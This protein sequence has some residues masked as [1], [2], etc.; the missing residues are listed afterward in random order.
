MG[1]DGKYEEVD[2]PEETGLKYPCP[3][4]DVDDEEEDDDGGPF[5]L[6]LLGLVFVVEDRTE[7]DDTVD[8]MAAAVAVVAVVVATA[9]VGG[10]RLVI[11]E[12]L[13]MLEMLL[14][15][16]LRAFD[17][18]KEETSGGG[19][20][21]EDLDGVELDL[22]EVWSVSSWIVGE[23]WLSVAVILLSTAASSSSS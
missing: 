18:A 16:P 22:P 5:G 14:T 12:M 11:L 9:V 10:D 15:L 23:C 6:V 21:L 19:D 1:N 7:V 20:D 13:E 2:G 8:M 3:E 4:D 17:R